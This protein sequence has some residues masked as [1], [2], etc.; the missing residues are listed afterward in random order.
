MNI[1]ETIANEL[2]IEKWQVEAAIEL[3]DQGNTIPFITRYR[4]EMTGSLDDEQLR[5]LSERLVELRQLH[6]RKIE[7]ISSIEEQNKLTPKL[8]DMIQRATSI[9]LVEDL[10][11]P[12]KPK[13]Q[14][15]GVIAIEKGLEGLSD[16]ITQQTTKKS[17]QTEAMRFVCEDRGVLTANEAISGALDII[18]ENISDNADYRTRIRELTLEKGQIL[19]SAA[20]PNTKSDYEMYYDFKSNISDLPGYRTLAFNRGEKEKFLV[21]KI[22]APVSEIL[23]F[24]ESEI[25]KNNN[26]NTNDLLKEAI[27][28]SYILIIAPSIEE[29]V[30][31]ILTQI[32]QT[33]A[34][35]V[36]GYNLH[37]LLMQPPITGKVVCG[38]D[39]AFRTGC[40]LAVVDPTGKVLHTD[41]IYP[42][43]PQNKINES[44][45][46]LKDL[47]NKYN[48]TLF[49][50]GNGTASRESELIIGQLIKEIKKPLEY[51]IV[52]EAGASVYSTSKAA[53]EE[54]PDYNEYQ[55]GAISIARRIQDPLAE[56]VKIDPKAIGVGQYQHDLNQEKL[57]HALDSVVERCVNQVGVDLNTASAK[58]MQHIAGINKKISKNIV[59][60]REEKGKFKNR[61]DLLK[62]PLIGPKEFQ[63]C[64]GFMRITDGDDPLDSTCVHPESYEVARKLISMLGLKIDDELADGSLDGIS[65]MVKD[66]KAIAKELHTG[67]PTLEDIIKELEKPARDPRAEMPKPI[68]RHNVLDIKDL[69]KGMILRGTVRNVTDFGAFV[70]I[71][72]HQ[73]GLIHI[74][75]MS[76]KFVKHPLDIISVGDIVKVKVLGINL[77]KKRINLTMKNIFK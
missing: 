12:F 61:S 6:E 38:W 4:K 67:V 28:D 58:L 49:S 64:A 71:G 8:K 16:I 31:E 52:S 10:Y 73:D 27:K 57:S 5:D 46:I 25:I 29:E 60:Y 33:H 41:Q 30:R 53:R 63:Q 51:V 3:L 21:V 55:R 20:D 59:K 44:K 76:T 32:A 23:E 75:E 68:L 45:E 37:Q 47:I 36:F 14:T 39:P 13:V 2:S 35:K 17:I 69:K 9:T 34:I 22:E 43:P 19:S 66:I 54:F 42:T 72:V 65:K 74:S 11:R 7:I 15:R 1:Q 24:L 18:A 70:D 77:G 26:P 50:V 40:K 48:I 62:V 56:L